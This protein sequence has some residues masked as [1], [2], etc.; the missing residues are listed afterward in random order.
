[1]H[2]LFLVVW[3]PELSHVQVEDL[4]SVLETVLKVLVPEIGELATDKGETFK[5][6]FTDIGEL[7]TQGRDI[8]STFH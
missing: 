1:M 7:A 4:A 2:L 5:V 3:G 8:Q 6:L